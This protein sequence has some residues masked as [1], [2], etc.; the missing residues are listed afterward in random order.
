MKSMLKDA[1]ILFVITLISG[2]VLGF[3][4]D[5][6]KEP[7]AA[8][9]V[10]KKN[11]AFRNVFPEADSFEAVTDVSL[12]AAG[13]LVAEQG[14]D[15]AVEELAAAYDSAGQLL[16]FVI[17]VTDHEGYGGD[18]TF[19][20]GIREDGTCSGVSILSIA[21]TAG[22]G[23]RAEE[24]LVPQM[25]GKDLTQAISYTKSGNATDSEVD[26]ISGATITTNAF[27]NGINACRI[28][29]IELLQGKGAA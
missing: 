19:A 5:L 7:I 21:E 29:F 12:E 23:M 17:T 18:I 22:L 14:L 2:L 27:V 9:A 25:P 10:E 6:T 15:A 3:V 11:E 1:A 8:Q 26:A 24:V 20:A 28:V 4:Y 16:G 13:E